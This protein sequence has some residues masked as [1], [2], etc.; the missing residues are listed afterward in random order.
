MVILSV[1]AT[2]LHPSPKGLNRFGSMN[3]DATTTKFRLQLAVTHWHIK[4]QLI[5]EMQD[6]RRTNSLFSFMCYPKM[7]YHMGCLKKRL[8]LNYAI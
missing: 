6:E 3:M 1:L 4:I 5:Q 7:N 8:F 2:S